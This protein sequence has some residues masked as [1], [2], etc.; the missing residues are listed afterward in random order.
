MAAAA[1]FRYGSVEL[2][3]LNSTITCTYELGAEQFIEIAVIPGGDLTLPGVREAAEIYYWLAGVSYI[4]TRAPLVIDLGSRPTTQ[5]ERDFLRSYLVNG[6]GEFALKND[7]DLTS[8]EVIG[9][10]GAVTPVSTGA[11]LGRLLIPFG[12]GLDSIVTVAE[13]APLA[14]DAALFVA[15]R[16]GA[17]FEAIERPAAITRLRVERAERLLDPKVLQSA[18]HG[19]LNGHVPVTGVLSALAVVTA[20]ATGRGGVAM[21]NERSASSAT[22][23]GPGG[24]VNHQWSKGAVFEEGFRRLLAG[25]LE[26][27]EYFS[28]LRDRSELS[29]AQVFSELPEYHHAFRSCNRSFHQDPSARLDHW[30]GVCDKCL[31]IDLV[32]SPFLPVDELRGIFDGREPLENPSLTE[33][34]EVLVGTS[35]GPRPFECVGDLAECQAALLLTVARPDRASNARL[36]R[37]ARALVPS[38]DEARDPHTFIPDRYAPRARLV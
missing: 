23:R 24:P 33:Q 6:L 25:R 4:K 10:D 7:L 11:D 22:T 8:L 27:I 21:S 36:A 34:L 32:L 20:L 12:G 28:W 16:P 15:E 17:R 3:P 9:T 19:Y 5:S 37:I 14:D 35:T 13:L 1:P 2:D 31:F 29:I 38:N 18:D 26:G 30:C